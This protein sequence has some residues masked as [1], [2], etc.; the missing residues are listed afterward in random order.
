MS[1][2]A[3]PTACPLCHSVLKQ[4][5]PV[6]HT[7]TTQSF[8]VRRWAGGDNFIETGETGER[9]LH[10]YACE[11]CARREHPERFRDPNEWTAYLEHRRCVHCDRPIFERNASRYLRMGPICCSSNCRNARSNARRAELAN[12]SKETK[13]VRCF[14]CQKAFTPTRRDARFCSNACRQKH[15]RENRA[16]SY[17]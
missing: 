1:R 12:L 6:Y 9:W 7:V 10:W 4:D 15:Y 8:K 16:F 14:T 11:A 2:P 13:T 5:E 3:K 17:R